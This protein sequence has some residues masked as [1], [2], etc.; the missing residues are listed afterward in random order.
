MRATRTALLFALGLCVGTPLAATAQTTR[1]PN[2]IVFF[3]EWSA[4]I[5]KPAA[6]VIRAA[7]R[8]AKVKPNVKILVTGFADTVGSSQ[9]NVYLTELRAQVVAD[10]LQADGLPPDRIEQAAAGSVPSIATRQESRRVTI[11]FEPSP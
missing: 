8:A 3:K 10:A 9:A 2:F 5:D 4:A 11:T 7:A 1:N 6:S